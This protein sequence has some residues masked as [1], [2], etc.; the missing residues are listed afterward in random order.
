MIV[1]CEEQ[2]LVLHEQLIEETGGSSGLN[3][4]SYHCRIRNMKCS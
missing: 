4:K 3:A 2:I 1:L